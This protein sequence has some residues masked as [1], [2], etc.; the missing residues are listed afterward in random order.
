MWN[1]II[2]VGYFSVSRNRRQLKFYLF[3]RFYIYI[4]SVSSDDILDIMANFTQIH[5]K[6]K[7]ESAISSSLRYNF[8][9]SINV[10]K[11]SVK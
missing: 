11:L 1:F 9:K 3:V 7:K 8:L 5:V 2:F 4:I 10:D 6:N